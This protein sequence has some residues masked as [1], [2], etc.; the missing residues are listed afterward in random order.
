MFRTVPPPLGIGHVC[1][2]FVPNRSKNGTPFE[3]TLIPYGFDLGVGTGTIV[4]LPV[5]GSSV[6][7]ILPTCAVNQSIP[8][9]SKIGLWGSRIFGSGI[10]YSVT[11]PVFGS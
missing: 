11:C 8:R 6:P 2:F 5:F 4:I 9:L 7:T 1:I 10:L 3:L